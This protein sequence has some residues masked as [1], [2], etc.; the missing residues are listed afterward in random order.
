MGKFVLK[1]PTQFKTRVQNGHK[2]HKRAS[3]ISFWGLNT[4]IAR[5]R[6]YPPPPPPHE[7]ISLLENDLISFPAVNGASV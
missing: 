1:G 6:E 3:P 4:N 2:R 7:P 5:I